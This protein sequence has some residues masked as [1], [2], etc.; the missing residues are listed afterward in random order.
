MELNGPSCPKQHGITD[1]VLLSAGKD[2]KSIADSL[3]SNITVLLSGIPRHLLK[4]DMLAEIHAD[5]KQIRAFITKGIQHLSG[6]LGQTPSDLA[7]C[8]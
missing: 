8:L 1:F 6:A 5:I 4:R 7:A 2:A 3:T